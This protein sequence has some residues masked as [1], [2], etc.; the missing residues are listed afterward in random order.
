MEKWTKYCKCDKYINHLEKFE[1]AGRHFFY[2]WHC[3]IYFDSEGDETPFERDHGTTCE[4]LLNE[5]RERKKRESEKI[6]SEKKQKRLEKEKRL[7]R[8][9]EQEQEERRK[10]RTQLSDHWESGSRL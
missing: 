6:E 7:L 4:K 8:E 3:K 1:Y 9:K 2:C 10:Q 5:E